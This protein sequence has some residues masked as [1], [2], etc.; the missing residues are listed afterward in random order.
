MTNMT[1]G[2]RITAKRKELSLS[3]ER[4]GELL[5]VSRQA[6]YKWES[7][8]SLPDIDKLVALSRQFQ[9]SVGW[10]LGVEQDAQPAQEC[11]NAQQLQL[12]EE[13]FQKYQRAAPPT[14]P[15]ADRRHQLL[16]AGGLLSA[17]LVLGLAGAYLNG[18]INQLEGQYNDLSGSLSQISSSFNSQ[19]GY[20]T[21][22]IQSTLE[23]SSS[24]ISDCKIDIAGIDTTAGT[25]TFDLWVVPKTAG[26][27]TQALFFA[28]TGGGSVQAEGTPL[29]GGFQGHL[30]AELTDSISLSVTFVNGEERQNQ[31]LNQFDDL[32][33]DTLPAGVFLSGTDFIERHMKKN[34]LT[35]QPGDGFLTTV[36]VA[37]TEPGQV[38]YAAI[39]DIKV[40]LFRNQKL[41]QWLTP[42]GQD[43]TAWNF[44]LEELSLPL[45][46][47][48][49]VVL[50]AVVTDTLGRTCVWPSSTTY[51]YDLD[52]SP[53]LG[54]AYSVTEYAAPAAGY[55]Y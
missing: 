6:I 4:L 53:S 34:V 39:T 54:T 18:R 7:D 37:Y 46:E 42:G 38:T 14:S 2:Q 55:E 27:Q 49:E 25:V 26:E 12:I 5:G 43:D 23:E 13:I 19:V 16:L 47:H 28:H 8:A 24:L 48:D 21:Q 41:V 50:A 33:T 36:E 44:R 32:Y 29:N 11:L 30:T 17:V 10:L 51:I 22:Q 15:R 45:E 35:I 3:Q 52:H 9:V 1:T 31:L 20:L 40:G